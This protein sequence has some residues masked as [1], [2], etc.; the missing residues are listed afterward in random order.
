VRHGRETTFAV[1]GLSLIVT[2]AALWWASVEWPWEAH[3]RRNY[4]D[5]HLEITSAA[6]A[7]DIVETHHF[8]HWPVPYWKVIALGGL[9]LSRARRSFVDADAASRRSASCSGC[10][11][12]L[13]ATPERCPECGRPAASIAPWPRPLP[14]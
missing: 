13:R 10:G 9:V 3:V 5:F 11:Y 4:G 8:E 12:D 7:F 2:G 6:G 14:E 1:L